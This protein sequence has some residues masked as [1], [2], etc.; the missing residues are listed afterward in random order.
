[1]WTLVQTAHVVAR[2]FTQLFAE[3]GLTPTQFGVLA[4][5]MDDEGLSQAELARRVLVRPQSM[6]ELLSVLT[7]RGLVRRDGPAGRGR[8]SGL[9]ITT[10]GREVFQ[11]ALPRVAAFHG[12][13]STGLTAQQLHTL[14]T[15]L[16]T[17]L[18]TQGTVVPDGP[19]GHR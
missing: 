14:E 13:E 15:L 6:G 10:A 9:K 1:M 12:P 7:D 18:Q 19:A 8:R 2:R 16:Q 3:F 17:L 11:A 4:Y 5:L